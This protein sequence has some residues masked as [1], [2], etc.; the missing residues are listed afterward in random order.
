METK[1]P[2][3]FRKLRIAW[4]VTWGVAAVLVCVLWVRSYWRVYSLYENHYVGTEQ[5]TYVRSWVE[6]QQ[7]S[8]VIS[9]GRKDAPNSPRSGTLRWDFESRGRSY[10]RP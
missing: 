3:R 4:S 1:S 8:V 5:S 9:K 2:A 10:V 6:V 7:G